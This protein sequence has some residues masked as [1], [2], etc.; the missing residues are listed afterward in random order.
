M[1][2]LFVLAGVAPI[3]LGLGYILWRRFIARDEVAGSLVTG[4]ALGL[5]GGV[6]MGIV[7]SATLLLTVWA[8][9]R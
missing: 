3:I 8:L 7:V 4:V 2:L 6:L 1:I 5:A 9:T